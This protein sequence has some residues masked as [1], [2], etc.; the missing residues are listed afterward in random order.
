MEDI[1]DVVNEEDIVIS[2][3]PRSEVH[4]Q[5]LLHRS[6]HLL[7]H[8]SK[9]DFFLQKRSESKDTHPNTWTSSVSG[10]VDSGETYDK[11]VIRETVEEIGIELEST[12]EKMF[13][14]D[15]CEET[16]QEFVWVYRHQFDGE[17][18]INE[19]EIADGKWLGGETISNWIEDSPEEFS[20][21]FKLIWDIF[22]SQNLDWVS[23]HR[24]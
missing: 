24:R 10:H 23:S 14:I 3:L 15:A 6:V 19:E 5:G 8:N 7:I 21:S 4:S 1:F 17:L 2:Q 13:K 18:R 9:G 20:P 11:G 22:Q 12:P 16:D